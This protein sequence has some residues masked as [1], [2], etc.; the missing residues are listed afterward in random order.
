MQTLSGPILLATD[1]STRCDRAL[2]RA[3]QLAQQRQTSL[4][5]LHVME[6]HALASLAVRRPTADHM[7]QAERRLARDLAGVDVKTTVLLQAG[8]PVERLLQAAEEH[9]CAM[10][11]A[12]VARDETLGRLLL[13]TTVEKLARHAHQPVLVVKN[14]V[15]HPYR[16]AVVASDFSEGSRHALRAALNLLP[17]D[18]LTLVHAFDLPSK[19]KDES[20]ARGFQR[21]AQEAA[22]DFMAATPELQGG[23]KLHV[24][25]A[26][27]LPERVLASY[28]QQSDCELL[29]TGTQGMTGIL[30]TALGSVAES[31]L[32]Q[33]PC[34]VMIVRHPGG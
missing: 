6:P 30:R 21:T 7:A 1:L 3:V 31:L 19:G 23:V 24:Q 9:G 13:G 28:V 25:V 20:T 18:A 27:G 32:E 34:D 14:R 15:R 29:V 8:D 22:A 10:I 2:D 17:A 11:V 4:I 26:A 16:N 33:V 5:V 12:G